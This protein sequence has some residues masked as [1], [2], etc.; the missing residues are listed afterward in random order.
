MKWKESMKEK[1]Q[2]SC[3]D[4][5]ILFNIHEWMNECPNGQ[6][7]CAMNW[8]HENERNEQTE[9]GKHVYS[10]LHAFAF[11]WFISTAF[12]HSSPSSL[13]S[14]SLRLSSRRQ[15]AFALVFNFKLRA[16]ESVALPHMFHI[17]F[18]LLENWKL[19][20][21]C[22]SHE[23]IDIARIWGTMTT[24]MDEMEQTMKI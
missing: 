19:S 22:A 10:F 17:N 12:A 9:I 7:I 20:P 3:D 4:R 2:Q 24:E 11:R 16:I 18:Y 21:S 14:H 5:R 6:W 23:I 8:F 15:F 1:R 13:P